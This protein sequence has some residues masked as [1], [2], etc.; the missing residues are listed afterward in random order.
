MNPDFCYD[1][2]RLGEVLCE[3]IAEVTRE[4]ISDFRT[5]MGY[6]DPPKDPTVAPTSIGLIFG[7]RLGW[8]HAIFPPGVIRTGDEDEFGVPVRAG[9]T[10]RTQFSIAN[11]FKAKGRRFMNYEMRTLNQ[12]QELVCSI[13]FVGMIP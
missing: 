3:G 7:L 6:T 13:R 9:D 5:L 10:L 1:T 4:E 11:K 2:A 12:R 8:E